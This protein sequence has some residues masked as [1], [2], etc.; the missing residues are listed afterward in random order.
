MTSML[1]SSPTYHLVEPL[2]A[3]EVEILTLFSEGLSNREVADQ[4]IIAET[5]VKWYNQQIFDKFSLE[6]PEVA[7]L[8]PEAT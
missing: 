3:R 6:G 4:L 7:K 5:T 2:T 8:A 1:S